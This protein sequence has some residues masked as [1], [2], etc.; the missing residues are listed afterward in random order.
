MIKVLATTVGTSLVVRS[1]RKI[2]SENSI[3]IFA[4]LT[5]LSNGECS[6]IH[7]LAFAAGNLTVNPNIL[8]HKAAMLAADRSLFLDSMDEEIHNYDK[9]EI[10]ELI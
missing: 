1:S 3:S 4:N 8:Q 2:K 6:N 7:P 9:N 5:K 10:Y